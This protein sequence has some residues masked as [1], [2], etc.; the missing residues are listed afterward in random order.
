MP[1]IA[2]LA[3]TCEI[4]NASK[5]IIHDKKVLEDPNFVSIAV[6]SHLW[7]PIDEVRERD[8]AKYLLDKKK[9]GYTVLA[10]E[11]TANSI[12][13]EHFKFPKK[14]CILLGKEKEG[15]PIDFIQIVDKCIQIPQF[16]MIRSLNV[17]VSGAILLWSYV[18]D[19]CLE[20]EEVQD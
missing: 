11:Q 10:L 15:I 4:F 9:E 18:R 3:R 1:N 14:I 2:G 16:G 17:H 19:Q 5:L 20:I 13:L 7:M 6:T 8:V 12:S